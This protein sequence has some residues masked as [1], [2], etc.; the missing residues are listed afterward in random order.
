MGGPLQQ[1]FPNVRIRCSDSV[2]RPG[3]VIRTLFFI[4]TGLLLLG[5]RAAALAAWA[6]YKAPSWRLNRRAITCAKAPTPGKRKKVD[7]TGPTWEELPGEVAG[8]NDHH[9]P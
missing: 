2:L 3:S 4:A 6:V 7:L 8:R 1:R 9:W 5:L